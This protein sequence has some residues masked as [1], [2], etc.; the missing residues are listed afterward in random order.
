MAR[1]KRRPEWAKTRVSWAHCVLIWEQMAGGTTDQGIDEWLERGA[2]LYTA[3]RGG[4]IGEE[5]KFTL[6]LR[7]IDRLRQQLARV[8]EELAA[9]LPLSVQRYREELREKLGVLDEEK[10]SNNAIKPGGAV[11]PDMEEAKRRQYLDLHL[12]NLEKAVED[13]RTRLYNPSLVMRDADDER[14][15]LLPLGSH[16]WALFPVAYVHNTTPNFLHRE[17]SPYTWGVG[18]LQLREHLEDS[19]FILHLRELMDAADKLERDTRSAA[20]EVEEDLREAARQEF[21]RDDPDFLARWKE[22]LWG[23]ASYDPERW[24]ID[25][26]PDPATVQPGYSTKF[27]KEVLYHLLNGPM[28]DTVQRLGDLELL[29]VD[30]NRDLEP[31]VVNKYLIEGTCYSCRGEEPR[32]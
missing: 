30:L 10:Q 25:P 22:H 23:Y 28:P 7:T 4:K 20:R 18:F 29:L 19:P 2:I 14:P 15:Y 26:L 8:P 17:R 13:L 11:P 16:D 6:S 21:G 5:K 24:P 27:L 31:D 1:Q 12:R 3:K 32:W 9:T